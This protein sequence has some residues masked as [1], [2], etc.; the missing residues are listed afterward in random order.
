MVSSSRFRAGTTRPSSNVTANHQPWP[1]PRCHRAE[2]EHTAARS[3]DPRLR[4]SLA[5]PVA[6]ALGRLS[7][8]C[9]AP[10]ALRIRDGSPG[11]A[12][13]APQ[14]LSAGPPEATGRRRRRR[15]RPQQASRRPS[16]P[17]HRSERRR[18]GAKHRVACDRPEPPLPTPPQATSF[19]TP[20]W[21]SRAG[22]APSPPPRAAGGAVPGHL[23]EESPGGTGACAPR[24]ASKWTP[25]GRLC[26][27]HCAQRALS[28]AGE[29]AMVHGVGVV[30]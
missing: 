23:P 1:A 17:L 16:A 5:G 2:A 20:R 10:G 7:L 25:A 4:P 21:P 6:C 24:G 18:A 28:R 29:R 19:L 8:I 13:A 26:P 15:R 12:A 30:V 22:L 27:A 3:R 11:S 14:A 9:S